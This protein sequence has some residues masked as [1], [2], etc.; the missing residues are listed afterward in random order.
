MQLNLQMTNDKFL[1]HFYN[2]LAVC[3]LH[4]ISH[5]FEQGNSSFSAMHTGVLLQSLSG[6]GNRLY[7]SCKMPQPSWST[8][9]MQLNKY[10]TD[11]YYSQ[12]FQS[13]TPSVCLIMHLFC[14]NCEPEIVFVLICTI[15][16]QFH[17]HKSYKCVPSWINIV[18]HW[19]FWRKYKSVSYWFSCK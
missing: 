6:L 1:I 14:K 4:I 3:Q 2:L 15:A 7:K 9:C 18:V 10:E 11:P 16:E 8:V 5:V 17:V 13:N 19:K 12:F